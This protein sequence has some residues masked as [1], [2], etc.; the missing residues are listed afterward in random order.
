MSA[1]GPMA[2]TVEDDG[3][4]EAQTDAATREENA[5]VGAELRQ[6]HEQR[7]DHI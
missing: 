1:T 3:T 7:N 4:S 6:Q 5:V 2:A